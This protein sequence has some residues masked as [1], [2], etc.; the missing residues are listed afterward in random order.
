MEIKALID[1]E[2]SLVIGTGTIFSRPGRSMNWSANACLRAAGFISAMNTRFPTRAILSPDMGEEPVILC[3][4]MNGKLRARL[5]VCRH[6]GDRVSARQPRDTKL[7]TCSSAR[8]VNAGDGNLAPSCR[9]SMPFRGLDLPRGGPR[10]ID[11]YKGLIFATFDAERADIDR[12]PWRY[13]V[14]SRYYESGTEVG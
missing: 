14:V 7:F 8:L 4:D 10:P 2:G 9:W 5:N 1:P 11:S 3:R 6:R 12:L 13:G